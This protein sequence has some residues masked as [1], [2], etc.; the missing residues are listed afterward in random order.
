MEKKTTSARTPLD[1][2][3]QSQPAPLNEFDLNT[4]DMREEFERLTQLTPHDA[5]GE[6]AFI[7]S[8]IAMIR[9]DPH[10]ND[11]EK[12]RAIEDVLKSGTVK[13]SP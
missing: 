11:E 3:K 7:E 9:S 8:K 4:G 12:Q 10:L 1:P 5:Q 13:D 2:D 6:L